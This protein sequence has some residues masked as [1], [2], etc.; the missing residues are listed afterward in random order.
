MDALTSVL[1]WDRGTL[2]AECERGASVREGVEAYL[3]RTV[4]ADAGGNVVRVRLSRV[5][6]QGKRRVVARVTQ[7]DASGKAWG[8][9]SVSGDESCASLDEPL[10]LVVALLVDAP[11]PTTA[12]EPERAPPPPPPPELVTP[13][14]EIVTAP[15]FEESAQSPGHWVVLGFGAATLGATPELAVGAG[16]AVSVKPRGFWGLGLEAAGFGPS[17]VALEAG[18]LDLSLMLAAASLCPL[19]GANESAWWSACASFGGARLH[20]RSRGL[21]EARAESQWF[22]LPGLSV[23]A[24]RIVGKHWLLGGGVQ[25]GLP[26]GPDRYVYRDADGRRQA[27][28]QVSSLVLTAHVGIGWIVN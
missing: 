9:R 14:S 28:F 6:E 15:S 23:R 7:E 11:E 1:I 8:E 18:S 4:F 17:R 20:A 13:S 19:Q 2:E 10:T 3:G 21:L 25:A 12:V 22:A 16:L 24:A 26:I 27:A 5:E